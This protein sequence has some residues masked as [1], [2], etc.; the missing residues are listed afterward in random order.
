[1]TFFA[2]GREIIGLREETLEVGDSATVM[3]LLKLL[4]D[5]HGQRLREYLFELPTERPRPHLTILLD[6]RGISSV[7]GF[8]TL[9]AD[10][11]TLAIVPLVS[12]G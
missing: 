11:S 2:T 7:A 5:K 9:V 1:V 8:D 3:H 10:G 6:G 4:V 12:G